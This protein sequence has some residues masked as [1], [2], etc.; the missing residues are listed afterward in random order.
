MVLDGV[1]DVL[2]VPLPDWCHAATSMSVLWIEMWINLKSAASGSILVDAH[3]TETLSIL[4][5]SF[6]AL[7][8]GLYLLLELRP[9]TVQTLVKA[10]GPLD[11]AV[12][13]S[14]H[15]VALTLRTARHRPRSG[16]VRNVI[17]QAFAFLD[18][19][20]LPLDPDY[21]FGAIILA[22]ELSFEYGISELYMGCPPLASRGYVC[23][24]AAIDNFRVWWPPCPHLDDP[25]KCNPYAFLYPILPDGSRLPRAVRA[26]GERIHDHEVLLADVALP[27]KEHMFTDPVPMDT[28]GLLVQLRFNVQKRAELVD[29]STWGGITDCSCYVCASASS[30]RRMCAGC[31]SGC[32]FDN[33]VNFDG[34]CTADAMWEPAALSQLA[35]EGV[36]DCTELSQC[37]KQV[38]ECTCPPELYRRCRICLNE[39]AWVCVG[40]GDPVLEGQQCGP[41]DCFGKC[42]ELEASSC[43]PGA[44]Q[45]WECGCSPPPMWN[46]SSSG[47]GQAGVPSVVAGVATCSCP[48]GTV[49]ASELPLCDGSNDGACAEAHA[50]CDTNKVACFEWSDDGGGHSRCLHALLLDGTQEC[51]HNDCCVTSAAVAPSQS[52]EAGSGTDDTGQLGDPASCGDG[53]VQPENEQCDEGPAGGGLLG[54]CEVDCKCDINRFQ[55]DN[56]TGLCECIERELEQVSAE[57]SSSELGSKNDLTLWL[58][59]RGA[60]FGLQTQPSGEPMFLMP[61]VVVIGGLRQATPLHNGSR[62][63]VSCV[64]EKGGNP[65]AAEDCAVGVVA[66]SPVQFTS[67][68]G[69]WSSGEGTLRFTVASSRREEDVLKV[70]F[71]MRNDPAARTPVRPQVSVCGSSMAANS[72]VLGSGLLAVEGNAPHELVLRK[73]VHRQPVVVGS[74]HVPAD[75]LGGLRMHVQLFDTSIDHGVMLEARERIPVGY[76]LSGLHQ[77]GVE[78]LLFGGNRTVIPIDVGLLVD[79]GVRRRG[80]GCST[81]D[82]VTLC[83]PGYAGVF[84]YDRTQKEWKALSDLEWES[85]SVTHLN[86]SCLHRHRDGSVCGPSLLKRPGA[87]GRA[88]S[89]CTARTRATYAGTSRQGDSDARSSTFTIHST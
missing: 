57:E 60:T 38:Q 43:P 68:V 63:P 44:C 48:L 80:G 73:S 42:L 33:C 1:D 8:P 49:A 47:T 83:A 62:L 14:W 39:L 46:E 61:L 27:V 2:S 85:R 81:Q 10:W 36:C 18:G 59:I 21:D 77:T 66:G 65:D 11:P 34:D 89:R 79:S 26:T 78:I 54:S 86:I 51:G 23:L 82:G 52:L 19:S 45:E 76:E 15:H 16:V 53:I 29:E 37:P 32:S 30:S 88:V 3:A 58:K 20:P 22:S 74:M 40:T 4:R 5:W 24:H 84:A 7:D 12:I 64:I 70:K 6:S 69:A 87:N 72:Y 41:D 17:T 28:E 75:A 9:D 13:G 50:C 56:R 55:F 71:G 31:E 25:S 67:G 35:R